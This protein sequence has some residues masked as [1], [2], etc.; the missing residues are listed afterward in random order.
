M[1]PKKFRS[2]ILE[3]LSNSQIPQEILYLKKGAESYYQA[4]GQGKTIS[5]TSKEKF[6]HSKLNYFSF[7]EKI[8]TEKSY[9]NIISLGC[10]NGFQ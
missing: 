6:S 4:Y 3:G 7:I 1:Y 8:A 10:G 9:I 5:Q 2:L